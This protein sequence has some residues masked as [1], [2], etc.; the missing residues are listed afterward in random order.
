MSSVASKF[1]I[2]HVS[3]IV[4]ATALAVSLLGNV[5]AL[6]YQS[7]IILGISAPKYSTYY[8]QP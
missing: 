4:A 8:V 5:F 6:F 3:Y 2:G 7:N 1:K